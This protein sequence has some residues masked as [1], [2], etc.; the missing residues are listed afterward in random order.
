V[1]IGSVNR[2][3]PNLWLSNRRFGALLIIPSAFVL[4]VLLVAPAILTIFQSFYNVPADGIGIGEF[5]GLSNYVFLLTNPIFWES[6]YVSIVFAIIFISLSTI[7]GLFAAL[8]LNQ[9]FK[10]RFFLRGMLVLPWACP[11]LIVGVIWKWFGD[12]EIGLLNGIL[13]RLGIISDYKD[14]LND[15]NYAIWLTA[16]AASWRQSCLVGLLLLAGLQTLPRDLSDAASVDGAGVFQRF[17]HITLPWLRPSLTIVTVLNVIYGLMQ[18]DVIFAMT[19]GGPSNATTLLSFLIYRQF[20]IF[21]NFGIGSAIAV[22]LAL[23]AL[24]GGLITVKKVYK[25]IEI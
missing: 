12:G 14:F 23:L 6:V 8:L 16:I 9:S 20:F 19:Q 25:K 2:R 4:L 1:N 17:W 18:F 11:W 3:G 10:G 7:V 21:T 24:V 15:P 22:S 5:V 13:L